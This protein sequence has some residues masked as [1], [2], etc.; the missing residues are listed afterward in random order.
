MQNNFVCEDG[1][2]CIES[3]ILKFDFEHALKSK[4][5]DNDNVTAYALTKFD[6]RETVCFYVYKAMYCLRIGRNDPVYVI[7]AI[8]RDESNSD[9]MKDIFKRYG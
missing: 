8:R 1:N 2:A 3:A 4:V 5:G 9:R 6:R 7:G